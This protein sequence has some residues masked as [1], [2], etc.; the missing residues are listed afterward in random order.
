MFL[1]IDFDDAPRVLTGTD[2]P[3]VFGF[4]G[5]VGADNGKGDFRHDFTVF[6]DCFVIV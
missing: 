1:I 4:D 3:T 2:D 5:S 6:G